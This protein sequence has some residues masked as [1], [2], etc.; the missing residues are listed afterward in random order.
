MGGR[1]RRPQRE[2]RLS[3]RQAAAAEARSSRRIHFLTRRIDAAEVVDPEAPRSGRAA[4]HVFFGATV[5]YANAAGTRTGRQ[6]R[7]RG[8]SGSRPQQRQLGVAAGAGVD[9]GCAA[10]VYLK[11]ANYDP[12]AVRRR[13]SFEKC[14]N[15][16]QAGD[17]RTRTPHRIYCPSTPCSVQDCFFCRRCPM[18]FGPMPTSDHRRPRRR[19][20][21]QTRR[22]K[23]RDRHSKSL[24]A[25]A[26][27]IRVGCSIGF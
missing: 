24:T 7:R 16:I 2:R 18:L 20:N 17:G 10:L 5:R 15:W 23:I 25:P 9:E 6:H 13:E 8:R 11:P 27:P 21:A 26:V 12:R 4:T 1:Q 22:R 19:P 3:V 14:G